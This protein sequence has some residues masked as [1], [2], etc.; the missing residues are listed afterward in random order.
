MF[1]DNFMHICEHFGE[2]PTMVLRKIG[3]SASAY[4]N[5]KAG[6]TPSNS[7]KKK[8]ADHFGITIDELMSGQIKKPATKSDEL[9]ELKKE[10][11]NLFDELS[12]DLQRAAV[13]QM[14]VLRGLK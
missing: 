4:Q 6:G 11:S 5:W 2:A 14:K 12:E 9:T 13:A 10:A 1:F 3:V 7:T 8:L